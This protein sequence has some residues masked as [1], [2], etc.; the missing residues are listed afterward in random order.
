MPRLDTPACSAPAVTQRTISTPRL[1]DLLGGG[2]RAESRLRPFSFCN[3]AILH[4]DEPRA[5]YRERFEE[6][7]THS[8]A[9]CRYTS[10]GPAPRRS[11]YVGTPRTVT[12]DEPASGL[13]IAR[14]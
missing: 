4:P 14:S 11:R 13:D 6:Y 2:R 5:K 7:P 3:H 12:I 8:V 1:L 10:E 9:P